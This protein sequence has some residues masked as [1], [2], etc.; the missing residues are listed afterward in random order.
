MLLQLHV[1]THHQQTEL[2]FELR[3]CIGLR[4]LKDSLHDIVLLV[5][6]LLRGVVP[7]LADLVLV[8]HV[9][10]EQVEVG[11][12]ILVVLLLSHGNDVI[13][14]PTVV[15]LDLPVGIG[16]PEL[17]QTRVVPQRLF[18]REHTEHIIVVCRR[19][20][21]TTPCPGAHKEH[22]HTNG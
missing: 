1:G 8:V 4:L 7:S 9:L 21:A 10:F 20:A 13:T 11:K 18:L 2:W 22:Q 19:E 3:S 12:H 17:I 15:T 5:Q 16:I 6:L 14:L